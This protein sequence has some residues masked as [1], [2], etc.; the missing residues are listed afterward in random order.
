MSPRFIFSEKMS[1]EDDSNVHDLLN[2]LLVPAYPPNRS[3]WRKLELA[4]KFINVSKQSAKQSKSKEEVPTKNKRNTMAVSHG[5]S[6]RG[7][8][9]LEPVGKKPRMM[10]IEPCKTISIKQKEE[11]CNCSSWSKIK[12][13]VQ[14]LL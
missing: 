10:M 4:L 11:E 2:T 12:G 3:Q 9:Q 1:A 6:R 13:S 14:N 5:G 8:G 7:S